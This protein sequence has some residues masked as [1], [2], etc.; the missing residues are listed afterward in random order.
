[1]NT[2]TDAPRWVELSVSDTGDGIEPAVLDRLGQAFAL[3]SG[4]VDDSHFEGGGLGLAICKGIA[5]AHGGLIRI[6]SEQG[7]GTVVTAWLRADL[8]GPIESD[9]AELQV[10]C[11]GACLQLPG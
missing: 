8:P 3:N 5:A 2:A 4:V 6:D 1:V 9:P 10:V 7:K 11:R